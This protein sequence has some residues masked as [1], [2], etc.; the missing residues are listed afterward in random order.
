MSNDVYF[1]FLRYICKVNLS[2]DVN[3]LSVNFK[4]TKKSTMQYF[5]Y[6]KIRNMKFFSFFRIFISNYN[7]INRRN[8]LIQINHSLRKTILYYII[9]VIFKK[10]HLRK[11]MILVNP[12]TSKGFFLDITSIIFVI[13]KI[14]FS[15]KSISLRISP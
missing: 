4:K 6:N 3:T 13:K 5:C 2:Y 14:H 9:K 10:T 15:K 11:Y 1:L 7:N 8:V 12:H